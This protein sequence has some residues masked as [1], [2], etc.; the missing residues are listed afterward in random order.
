LAAAHYLDGIH[1]ANPAKDGGG[2]PERLTLRFTTAEVVVLGSRLERIEDKLA[3]GRLRG[4]RTIEP[5]LAA[6]IESGP[7]IF[8][9]TVNRKNEV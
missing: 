4:L 6:A 3:E 1:E 2:T 5:R 9:I 8:S 7:I